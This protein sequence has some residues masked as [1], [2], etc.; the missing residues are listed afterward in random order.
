MDGGTIIFIVFICGTIVASLVYIGAT[1][2]E[3]HNKTQ[4]EILKELVLLNAKKD[5]K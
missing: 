1:L 4:K 2:N 5:D 3:M